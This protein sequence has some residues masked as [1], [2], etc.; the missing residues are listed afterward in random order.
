MHIDYP[1]RNAAGGRGKKSFGPFTIA[2]SANLA[3]LIA[4]MPVQP[5]NASSFLDLVQ[6]YSDHGSI[7]GTLTL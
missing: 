4:E 7:A 6:G 5:E 1:D 3:D 2:T